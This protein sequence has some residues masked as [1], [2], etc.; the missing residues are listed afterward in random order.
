MD[1]VYNLKVTLQDLVIM[2]LAIEKITCTGKDSIA[3]ANIYSKVMEL[4]LKA[5][6]DQKTAI[7][8]Q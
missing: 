5:E 8:T 3:V 6:D 7:L 2:R 4:G 1:K